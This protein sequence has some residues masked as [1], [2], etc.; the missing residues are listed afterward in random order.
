M[1]SKVKALV[2][3]GYGLN[4]E[5][6]TSYALQR[7]GAEVRQMHLNDLIADKEQLT[8]SHLLAFIGGFSFGDHIAGG[9]VF[10]NRVKRT[11]RDSLKEFIENHGLIIGICNGF[12]TMV[13]MGLL[14][15]FDNDYETQRITLA[16]NDSGVFRNAWVRLKAVP[17]SRCVFTKGIDY[18]DVPIRHG[19]G[20][21]FVKDEQ[22]LKR[23]V[24][25]GQVVFRY[26]HPRTGEP[27]M[28][29]PHNPNG[30][31]DAVAG[32]CDPSGRIFGL[33]PHPEAFNSPY[34]HP[35]W[36]RQK[37]EGT[38]PE[39]GAGLRIFENGVDYIKGCL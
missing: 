19:E 9:R 18:L 7:A 1:V 35:H 4:C 29:F 12:Q 10:A 37:L 38:V 22:Y 23:L 30:S 28:E 36:L 11:L 34:N 25:Q 26:A 2:I 39:I 21:L 15:G 32:I 14:P 3:V 6:E 20:K 24:A 17:E 33:M 31:L 16:A 8:K 27:T 5:A 13:K